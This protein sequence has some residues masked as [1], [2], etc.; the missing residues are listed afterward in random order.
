[1]D[2]NRLLSDC[3]EQRRKLCIALTGM[4]VPCTGVA[5]AAPIDLRR[6]SRPWFAVLMNES[7]VTSSTAHDSKFTDNTLT[8]WIHR[9]LALISRYRHN[10]LRAARGLCYLHAVLHDALWISRGQSPALRSATA[11]RA[12][13]QMLSYLFPQ[14][15]G[16]RW[17]TTMG[18][19]VNHWLSD[20]SSDRSSVA[21]KLAGQVVDAALDRAWRDG[22]D[23]EWTADLLPPV[24]RRRWRPSPPLRIAT[25]LE[26]L[27]GEWQTW[28]LTDPDALQPP[29]PVSGTQ[30][31]AE[32]EEVWR[33]RQA[34]ND[35][36]KAIAEYWNLGRGTITPAGLWNQIALP[37][38]KEHYLDADQM[39]AALA[40]LN[41][42]MMDAL[43]VCWRTKYRWWT[44]RPVTAIRMHIDPGFTPWLL[45]PPFPAYVSGHATVSGAASRV[46][47]WL[48]PD[49]RATLDAMAEQAAW[50]RLLG[51]IHTRND[52]DAG[53]ALGRALAE[54]AI[55]GWALNG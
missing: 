34:L 12:V 40:L 3:D 48:M 2:S 46:L 29:S 54:A 18:P 43:I 19:A 9:L 1:M 7:A 15:G 55:A 51:G 23:R 14:E 50:S 26:A 20:A 53:L 21:S 5:T 47:A 33:T 11:H 4:C 10:P 13:A 25:P 35:E 41:A 42:V 31:T 39:T 45:T 24:D 36:E 22:S 44:E 37:L 16:V 30:A 27:A 6:R 52:N 38:L 8:E 49:R 32:L 28:I 17:S